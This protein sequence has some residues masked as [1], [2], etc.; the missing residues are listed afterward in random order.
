MAEI[1]NLVLEHAFGDGSI[2]QLWVHSSYTQVQWMLADAGN[3]ARPKKF[4]GPT[5]RSAGL[6][7]YHKAIR[8]YHAGLPPRH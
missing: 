5:A 7:A 6:A 8:R 4:Y 3:W 2:F 1:R